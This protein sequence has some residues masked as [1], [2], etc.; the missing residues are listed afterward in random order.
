M[1]ET[2]DYNALP[3][4]LLSLI[5]RARPPLLAQCAP[6]LF[7]LARAILALQ[8]LRVLLDDLISNTLIGFWGNRFDLRDEWYWLPMLIRN[9]RRS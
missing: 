6:P 7:E 2:N 4:K 1:S 3:L 8:L 5:S 9:F